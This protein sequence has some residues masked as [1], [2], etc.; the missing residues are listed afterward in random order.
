MTIKEQAE[1][2][3]DE[4]IN[5]LKKEPCPVKRLA[6]FDEHFKAVLKLKNDL[7]KKAEK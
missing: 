1:A 6:K 4:F 5:E 2:D 3:V 7:V